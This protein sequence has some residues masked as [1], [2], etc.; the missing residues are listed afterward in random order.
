M[1]RRPYRCPT[2]NSFWGAGILLF[3]ENKCGKNVS[4]HCDDLSINGFMITPY[5]SC[6]VY[7]QKMAIRDI[8]LLK[9]ELEENGITSIDD[10]ELNFKISDEDYKTIA[11]SGPISF[12]AK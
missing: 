9:S 11:E 12:K 3:V 5:F 4:V 6:T 8:T 2:E 1:L 7:D 10:V